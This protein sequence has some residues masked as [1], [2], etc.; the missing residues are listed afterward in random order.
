[1][2]TTRAQN[3]P[4]STGTGT[5]TAEGTDAGTVSGA[6]ADE[7]ALTLPAELL[8]WIGWSVGGTVTRATRIAGGGVNEGWFVDV[9]VNGTAPGTNQS[10]DAKGSTDGD[11]NGGE[12]GDPDGS[13]GDSTDGDGRPR[14]LFLRRNATPPTAG[15]AFHSLATEAEIVAAL[16]RAGAAVPAVHAVHPQ[17]EAVLMQRVTGETWFSRITDPREQVRVAQ[18]FIRV[19]A[20]IHRLDPRHLGIRA[21]G[22]VRSAREHALERIA[23]LRRRATR[24][25]GSMDPLIRFSADWLAANVPDYD[26]PVVLVQGDT[27]PGNFLY[28]HGR[29]TAVLDW[30]LAHWG[31]PMDDIAWLTLRS[32]QDTFT[33]VP[34]RLA[35]YAALS[36]HR[37]DV[38]RIHYYRVFAETT[39]ATLGADADET[40]SDGGEPPPRDYGNL[41]IYQQLHRRL[42]LQALSDAMGLGLTRDEPVPAGSPPPWD[43][44]YAQ[45]LSML[46]VVAARVDDPLARQWTKGVA[47][48]L[49]SLRELD[50]AG[51][52]AEA[53]E[54]ADLAA[55]LPGEEVVSLT[56]ARALAA[57]ATA[58]G[59]VGDGDYLRY[60]WRRVQRDEHLRRGALG[61]LGARTWPP[62]TD[63]DPPTPSAGRAG[64]TT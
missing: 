27:G 61:A 20:G 59:K 18:D 5:G 28:Q 4:A 46:R 6:G 63:D 38:G 53:A 49:R 34:D 50:A 37:L 43:P 22:P 11:E 51:R 21:L 33:H 41:H 19:L 45:A 40:P 29:V 32:V 16:R 31:D 57:D 25:D 10:G 9:T 23:D 14:K 12:D 26:G 30:E 47:R 52:V 64:G 62:L 17:H 56:D 8:S 58:V 24:P 36:G 15:S 3:P 48:L 35:E 60:L 54:L 7:G 13:T 44:L 2:A 42:W 39:M 1:M 55:L